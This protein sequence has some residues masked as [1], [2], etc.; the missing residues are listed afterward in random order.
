MR[1][2]SIDIGR[3][4]HKNER[5]MEEHQMMLQWEVRPSFAKSVSTMPVCR[6]LVAHQYLPVSC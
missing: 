3:R 2:Q 6:S 5:A 1:S 4:R